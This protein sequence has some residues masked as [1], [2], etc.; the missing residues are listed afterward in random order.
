MKNL[1]PVL[2]FQ[3]IFLQFGWSQTEV[4]GGIFEPTTWTEAESP[5]VV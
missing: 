1:I 2:L 5:Y 3:L 4:S